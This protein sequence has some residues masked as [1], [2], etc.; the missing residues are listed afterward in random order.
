MLPYSFVFPLFLLAVIPTGKV[1][2]TAGKLF[3][4]ASQHQTN[5]LRKWNEFLKSFLI[6]LREFIDFG[7]WLWSIQRRTQNSKMGLRTSPTSFLL[8]SRCFVMQDSS[9]MSQF[10]I[11]FPS[12][13]TWSLILPAAPLMLRSIHKQWKFPP[14]KSPHP[15]HGNVLNHCCFTTLSV[16]ALCLCLSP[17]DRKANWMSNGKK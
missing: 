4:N 1:Y 14:S 5:A 11:H 6:S 9:P 10:S 3:I 16:V 15:V 2:F 7:C 8:V 17:C 13:P 12:C